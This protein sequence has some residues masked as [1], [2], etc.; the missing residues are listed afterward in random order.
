[1]DTPH[2][3]ARPDT[4]RSESNTPQQQT[5][6]TPEVRVG[7]IVEDNLVIARVLS[8]TSL[9]YGRQN[10]PAWRILILSGHQAGQESLMFKDHLRRVRQRA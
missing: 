8:E 3:L 6:P 10:I 9:R 4:P 7:D 5:L 1:M 2:A